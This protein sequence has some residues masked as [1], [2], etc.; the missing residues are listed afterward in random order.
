M[1]YLFA[2]VFGAGISLCLFTK[3]GASVNWLRLE[4]IE[5]LTTPENGTGTCGYGGVDWYMWKVMECNVSKEVAEEWF[6]EHGQEYSC[7]GW[8]CDSCSDT[9]YCGSKDLSEMDC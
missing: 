4:N 3:H 8:C 5:A 9:W 2:F 6:L 1:I 7:S